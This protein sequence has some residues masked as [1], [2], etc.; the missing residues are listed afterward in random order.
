MGVG[1]AHPEAGEALANRKY[2]AW[3]RVAPTGGRPKDTFGSYGIN[4]WLYKPGQ[5]PLYGQPAKGYW[6]TKNLRGLSNIPLFLDCWFWCGGPENDD[7]PPNF[8]QAFS[9]SSRK[10]L[11]VLL[12]AT[13]GMAQS[14]HTSEPSWPV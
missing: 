7:P 3:G 6:R 11:I 14:T 4:H 8:A 9:G 10:I 13:G 2:T 5:D 1:V 12:I